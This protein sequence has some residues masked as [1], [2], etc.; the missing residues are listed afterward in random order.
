AGVE[1]PALGPPPPDGAAVAEPLG[2]LRHRLLHPP[3]LFL[4][5]V[6]EALL[7]EVLQPLAVLALDVLA[8]ELLADHGLHQVLEIAQP[9]RQVLVELAGNVRRRAG[10][11]APEPLQL[12]AEL[13]E[14]ARSG[15]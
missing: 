6:E 8:V 11:L 10:Q 4:R 14:A 7:G 15:H 3:D 13:A 1:G 12:A 5:E 2:E 9:A